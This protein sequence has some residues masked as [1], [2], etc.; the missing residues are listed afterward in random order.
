MRTPITREQPEVIRDATE[1]GTLTV[2]DGTTQAGTRQGTTMVARSSVHAEEAITAEPST[3]IEVNGP[4]WDGY[5]VETVHESD[6][7]I[8]GRTRLIHQASR[9]VIRGPGFDH[10]SPES[11]GPTTPESCGFA[12]FHAGTH[13][14]H[15]MQKALRAKR[16]KHIAN[17]QQRI[18]QLES[19]L[20]R[21]EQKVRVLHDKNETA[22]LL[23]AHYKAEE[24]EEAELERRGTSRFMR[25]RQ[26]TE[27]EIDA[28]T[29]NN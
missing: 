20:V 27:E 5:I 3:D 13:E 11:G 21:Q 1:T 28:L 22:Q 29:Q 4:H 14:M 12:R 6:D 26:R 7:A 18:I 19:H 25:D 2:T 8:R 24:D 16:V 9:R 17:L 15:N 10:S 23:I